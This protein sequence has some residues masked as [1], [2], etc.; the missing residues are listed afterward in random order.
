MIAAAAAVLIV[1]LPDNVAPESSTSKIQC[2][3]RQKTIF[4]QARVAIAR[5]TKR[6]PCEPT[7]KR[8][9]LASADYRGTRPQ[10]AFSTTRYA[11]GNF[12]GFPNGRVP[13]PGGAALRLKPRSHKIINSRAKTRLQ[14]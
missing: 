5:D 7:T 11:A 14:K 12:R 13:A 6:T 2:H 8:S 10:P 3:L 9:S 4:T 1:L